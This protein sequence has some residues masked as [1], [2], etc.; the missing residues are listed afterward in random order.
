MEHI[1]QGHFFY[2]LE[3]IRILEEQAEYEVG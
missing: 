1:K 3:D 2:R